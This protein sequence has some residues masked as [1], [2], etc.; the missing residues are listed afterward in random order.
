MTVDSKSHALLAYDKLMDMISAGRIKPGERLPSIPLAEEFGVSRTPVIEALKRMENEGIVVFKSGNGAW[1]IDPTKREIRDV[2]VVRT[3]L[4]ALALDLA[5]E[6]ISSPSL[7]GL[8]KYVELEQEYFRLGEKINYVKAGLDFHRE[9]ARHCGNGYLVHSI[10]SVMSTT[11]AYLL[12]FEP[13]R[14]IAGA[15][16]PDEHRELLDLIG[17]GRRSEAKEYLQGH[18]MA[19]FDANFATLEA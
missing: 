9:L 11:Y 4:E 18:L 19:S 8:G 2:Y 13:E 7:I 14:D 17:A 10:E 6:R 3:A 5:F 16:Y 1:V 15:R 12:L